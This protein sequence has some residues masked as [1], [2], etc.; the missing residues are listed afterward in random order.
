MAAEPVG[1]QLRR[2]REKLGLNVSAVADQQH[3]RPSVIQA[4][5]S[6]D[7]SKIDTELFL[8]GYVRAYARQVG[9]NPDSMVRELDAEL[10]PRRKEREQERQAHPLVDMERRRKRKRQIA[11][12]VLMLVV[13]AL[14]ALLVV[15]Y[16]VRDEPPAQVESGEPAEVSSTVSEPE[17]EPDVVGPV[18]DAQP[19]EAEPTETAGGQ[20]L[21]VNS[22]LVADGQAGNDPVSDEVQPEPEPALT[23]DNAGRLQMTFSDDCWV[24]VADATG[25][26]LASGL[27]RQGSQVDVVGEPPLKVVVGAMSAVESIRFQGESLDL[28]SFRVV[29]NRS[30]FMLEL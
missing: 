1:Q 27:R 25:N 26:R 24:Q 10:E 7:Y 17:P 29:N 16:L 22:A 30:E 19:V 4:I 12:T 15:T 18:S 20:P 5:E 13:L 3:L 8:K 14:A 11:K 2:A 9:L 28:G 6:G 21:A 23:S